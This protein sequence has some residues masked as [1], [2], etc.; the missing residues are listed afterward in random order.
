MILVIELPTPRIIKKKLKKYM[1]KE[2]VGI[3]GLVVGGIV[4]ICANKVPIK[5]L[6]ISALLYCAVAYEVLEK[7][8]YILEDPKLLEHLMNNQY[9]SNSFFYM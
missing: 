1:T 4:I 8:E 2:R 9:L 5:V 6:P 3:Y 7:S